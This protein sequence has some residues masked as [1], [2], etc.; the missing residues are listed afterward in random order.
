MTMREIAA[1]NAAAK[2]QE[3]EEAQKKTSPL[4]IR[5]SPSESYKSM[6][7]PTRP[8][9]FDSPP[10]PSPEDRLVGTEN[11]SDVIP[12]FPPKSTESEK[13]WQ[14]ACLLPQSRMGI[15]MAHSSQTGWLALSRHGKPPLLLFPLPVLGQLPT[16]PLDPQLSPEP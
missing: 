1:A 5:S 14:Q 10:S 7:L 9:Q 4:V 13:L 11:L 8:I 2:A 12:N 16:M 15:I 6:G 3:Q